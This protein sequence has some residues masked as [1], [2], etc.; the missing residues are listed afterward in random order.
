MLAGY[1]AGSLLFWHPR[2]EDRLKSRLIEDMDGS[3][4]PAA[5]LILDGQQRLTAIAQAV[6]GAGAYRFYV[7]LSKL[8]DL[9][10]DDDE[11]SPPDVT[12][13]AL[14]AALVVRDPAARSKAKRP[15]QNRK[16][17]ADAL[18]FPI[19]VLGD[20]AVEDWISQVD[21]IRN[22]THDAAATK[23]LW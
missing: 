20:D 12:V 23:W 18:L 6:V 16:E 11:S 1:P 4:D 17:E 3:V 10:Y 14:E 8:D 2:A 5:R 13:T 9:L 19:A 15:P 21:S 7:D 22:P